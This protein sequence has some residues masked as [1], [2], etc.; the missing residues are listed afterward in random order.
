MGESQNFS[1]DFSGDETIY[2]TPDLFLAVQ[3]ERNKHHEV[4]WI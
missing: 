3:T 2:A 4:L 1:F